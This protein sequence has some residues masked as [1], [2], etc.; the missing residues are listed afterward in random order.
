[1]T[2]LSIPNT[3]V[4]DTDALASEMNAN[5]QAIVDL[6]N[7]T[8]VP[9]VQDLTVTNGMLAADARIPAGVMTDFLGASAPTGWLLC[10]GQAVSR[11]TYADLFT[12]IGTAY[13]SGDGSTT[14]N[15]PDLR[16]RTAFGLDNMGGSDAG[17]LDVANTIGTT[18]GAQK[19][20]LTNDEVTNATLG[21]AS[22]IAGSFYG[23]LAT[24]VNPADAHQ[25]MPPYI[26]VN[27]IVKV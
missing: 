24:D 12:A 23:L 5:F 25:N 22:S 26:L 7:T 17:R 15:L 3:F 21:A 19:V 1:M 13:G 20:S 6:I 9:K 16:G 11:T 18:G 4:S 8:G 2:D 10:H 14:F 27:K